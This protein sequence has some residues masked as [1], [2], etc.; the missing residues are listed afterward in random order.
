MADTVKLVSTTT[1]CAEAQ[2]TQTAPISI[3]YGLGMLNAALWGTVTYFI[4]K[5]TIFKK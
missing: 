4:A 2:A 1:N 5:H 3:S